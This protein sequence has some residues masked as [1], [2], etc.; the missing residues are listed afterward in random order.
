[1]ADIEFNKKMDR[2]QVIVTIAHIREVNLCMK[3]TREW[4]AHHGFPWSD[5]L[6]NGKP[7]EELEATG[8]PL[9]FRVTAAARK[10]QADGK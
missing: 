7:A 1:M 8:D 6:A 4:F 10:G 2:Q 5:F 3:G 9:A